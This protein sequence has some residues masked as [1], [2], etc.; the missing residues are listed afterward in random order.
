MSIRSI[1]WRLFLLIAC[2]VALPFGFATVYLSVNRVASLEKALEGKASTLSRVLVDQTRS[3]VAFDDS[4]TARE[5]FDAV[6]GDADVAA[7]ALFR[8]D[9][10]LLAAIGTPLGG[11]PP[12]TDV[13]LTSRTTAAVRVAAPVIAREGPRGLLVLDLSTA[14]ATA[15]GART[16]RTAIYIGVAGLLFGC[17]A[18]WLVGTSFGRRVN[19]IRDQAA[20]VAGGDLSAAPLADASPDEIGQLA[21]AFRGM[22]RNLQQAYAGIE[23]QVVE[24]TEALRASNEQN[25]ALLE[26]TNAVPWELDASSPD[27]PFTYIGP[28]AASLFGT[29][30]DSWSTRAAWSTLLE[31]EDVG[32]VARA[33]EQA[34]VEQQDRVIEFRI[35]RP[36]GR[37]LWIRALIAPVPGAASAKVRGFMFDVTERVQ[38]EME[39]RQAHK[40]E[41]VGRLASGVAHEINTPIQFVSD[42]VHFVKDTMTDVIGT[43][44]R[45]RQLDAAATPSDLAREVADVHQ[46]AQAADLE[47][48]AENAPPALE[49]ALD[50]LGRVATIVRS[51]KQF[52]HPDAQG[53]AL[54]DLNAALDSTLII[55]RNEYKEV[56]DTELRLG[57]L[58]SVHCHVGELN[59]AFLN[60]V[61]NAAHAIGDVVKAGGTRGVI[62]V[63]TRREG[64]DAVVE[65]SDTGGG[66]PVEVQPRI[67]DPFFT[68]KGVGRGTGQGLAI[69]HRSVVEK[70]HGSLSFRTELGRGTTFVIRV[71]IA[72]D[73]AAEA[74]VA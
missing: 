21:Q 66:I 12:W 51:M 71:P 59:Q 20:R 25:R 2:A 67:F 5:V 57:D 4:Q 49:R 30:A 46:A 9:G 37:P 58:P 61:V 72:G 19:R 40:L 47:Y 17:A 1:R 60:I 7:L 10:T 28:Q 8:A 48:F 23:R 65:I 53:K 44:N 15:D 29:P 3:A 74:L 32:P 18:A 41:S 45:Y 13:P 50:G 27:M 56:A 73:A 33:F 68:T 26:T 31:P 35:R 11:S 62:T 34:A 39:L 64:D 36:S 54:A 55:A 16:R 6:S 38:L 63:V 69:A 22:V 70:H 42:S 24:R 43:L 52:A 14:S